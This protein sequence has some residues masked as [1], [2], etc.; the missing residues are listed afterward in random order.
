M[1]NTLALVACLLVWSLQKAQAAAPAEY[2]QGPLYSVSNLR[3]RDVMGLRLG[4]NEAEVQAALLQNGF[5]QKFRDTSPAERA[6]G[7]PDQMPVGF[8]RN[9]WKENISVSYEADGDGPPLV[10]R[11]S[12]FRNI[13]S[14]EQRQVAERRQEV[15]G[16]YGMPSQWQK[17]ILDD[18]RLADGMY[19]VAAKDMRDIVKAEQ[20]G[21]CSISG[22]W[23]C[24]KILHNRDC[25]SILAANHSPVLRISFGW[26]S[27]WYSLD[28]YGPKYRSLLRDHKFRNLDV[29]DAVC[30]VGRVH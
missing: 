2:V 21:T 28:D 17:F 5:V 14:E 26:Q 11:I 3:Q 6:E 4:M 8:Y 7:K 18:G 16:R 30:P 24:E 19:Y 22:L 15:I 12:Y 1:K 29:S 10:T 23:E 13:S 27:V 20:V 9:G 25:R